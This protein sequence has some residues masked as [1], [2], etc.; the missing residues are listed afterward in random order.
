MNQNQHISSNW[1]TYLEIIE[2]HYAFM[3][4][5]MKKRIRENPNYPGGLIKEIDFEQKSFKSAMISIVFTGIL[6]ESLL[7][8]LIVQKRG[9]ENYNKKVDHLEY[10]EK[11]KLLG[12]DDDKILV[13]CHDYRESRKEIVHEKAYIQGNSFKTAQDEA[14]RAVEMIYRVSKYLKV[15]ELETR[16]N[17]LFLM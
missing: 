9:I 14:K 4:T 5:D 7:H 12:C 3:I 2:E 11:L 15:S 13:L 6:L 16:L 1:Y 8:M 10:E 17:V